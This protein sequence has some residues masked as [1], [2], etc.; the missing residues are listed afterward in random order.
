MVLYSFFKSVIF[1]LI[2]FK[3]T[4][5]IQLLVLFNKNRIS[6][7]QTDFVEDRWAGLVVGKGKDCINAAAAV[8][9]LVRTDRVCGVVHASSEKILLFFDF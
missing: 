6:N 2:L 7:K 4:S 3:Y 5:I 8:I 1:N 9:D